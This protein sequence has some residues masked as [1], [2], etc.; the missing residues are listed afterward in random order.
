QRGRVAGIAQPGHGLAHLADRAALEAE[1]ARVDDGLV[2]E[3]ERAQAD[4][5][6]E[7]QQPLR[8]AERGK[9]EAAPLGEARRLREEGGDR[10][11]GADGVARDDEDASFA[12]VAEEGAA[13]G[14]AEQVR[15]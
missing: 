14:R 4:L 3:V 1:R 7:R 9:A 8:R 15:V 2:S 11:V 13:V 12:S 10:V 6:V 5:L